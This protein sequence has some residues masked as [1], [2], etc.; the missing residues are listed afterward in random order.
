MA[1]DSLLARRRSLLHRFLG[2]LRSIDG[3]GASR[4]R[5]RARQRRGDGIL[6]RS[7]AAADRARRRPRRADVHRCKRAVR[8]DC[9]SAAHG[10]ASRGPACRRSQAVH[11]PRLA[12]RAGVRGRAR[13]W[14]ARQYLCGRDLGLW[15]SDR[16]AGRRRKP[17]A[18]QAWGAE[19]R[20]HE[21]ALGSERRSG[22]DLEDRRR[23]RASQPLRQRD[24]R[25]QAQLRRG[26]PG[27]W[28]TTRTRNRS[29][30]RTARA[31]SFIVSP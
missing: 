26:A 31:A 25:R 21:R 22:I 6:R 30:S 13:R 2:L 16:R 23:D 18:R 15:P 4:R 8:A 12:G 10:R 24:D 7:A 9:R 28:P 17:Q 29:L 5:H 14:R 11:V 19:R 27:R 20:L 1:C 3:A